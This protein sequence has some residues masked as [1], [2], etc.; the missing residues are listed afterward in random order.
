MFYTDAGL[1]QIETKV[2]P[3]E[4]AFT[5]SVVERYY[6]PLR[7]AY[8]IITQEAPSMDPEI[9]LQAA[10]KSVN[11][12]VRPDGLVT[13][14]L[15]YG[16]LPELERATDLPP[17]AGTYERARAVAK[18]TKAVSKQFAQ[19]QVRDALRTRNEPDV[20]D[21]HKVPLG[22]HVLVYRIHRAE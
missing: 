9:A 6:V 3:V 11:S 14:L 2:V 16:A 12:S 21:I 17:A 15:V 5:N 8:C 1:F 19:Q 7:R 18:T 4:A 10:V 22:A 13:T 20:T